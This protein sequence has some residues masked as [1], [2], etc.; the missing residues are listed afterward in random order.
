MDMYKD[1]S[2]LH[3]LRCG[4]SSEGFSSLP[5]ESEQ[6]LMANV[7]SRP[8]RLGSEVAGREALDEYQLVLRR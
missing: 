5:S 6:S 7:V 4:R 3:A 2:E 8:V 1:V